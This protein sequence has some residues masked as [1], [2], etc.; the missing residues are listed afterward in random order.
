VAELENYATT[1]LLNHG[2]A[3]VDYVCIA[4]A[5]TL[6]PLPAINVD[7]KAVALIAAFLGDVRL[8]D[9]IILSS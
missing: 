9:N 6:Q 2:F 5:E 8:I 3:K 1:F 7:T 4:D